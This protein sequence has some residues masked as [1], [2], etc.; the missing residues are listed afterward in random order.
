MLE[1][2]AE[3]L[4]ELIVKHNRDVDSVSDMSIRKVAVD[5]MYI[6]YEIAGH[7]CKVMKDDPKIREFTPLHREY[8][9]LDQLA[10]QNRNTVD[11]NLM[12]PL[13]VPL[14]IDGSGQ[15]LDRPFMLTTAI[16]GIPIIKHLAEGRDLSG[17][18]AITLGE[19]IGRFLARLGV[20]RLKGCGNL[21]V[22]NEGV[23]PGP[24][25]KY[26][27]AVS[28][29]QWRHLKSSGLVEER[30]I[31]KLAE[32]TKEKQSLLL[33]ESTILSHNDFQFANIW[34]DPEKNEVTGLVNFSQVGS[35]AAMMDLAA[36]SV[37]CYDRKMFTECSESFNRIRSLP[38]K[39]QERLSYYSFIFG[40]RAAWFFHQH[41]DEANKGYFLRRAFKA[42]AKLDKNFSSEASKYN[43]YEKP[44]FG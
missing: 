31:D 35:G 2:T 12:I 38:D 18:I 15:I 7:W 13:P 21:S 28:D 29:A 19:Q 36:F 17:D 43:Q 8:F 39:W 33:G 4:A 5:P 24:W 41:K 9:A 10:R 6:T 44:R 34:F 16:R 27:L 3:I 32:L 20:V 1:P 40:M 26:L 30:L 11:K 14:F 22:T 42:A 23:H 25:I 37:Y